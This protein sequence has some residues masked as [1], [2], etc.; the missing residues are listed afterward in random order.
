MKYIG[1]AFAYV[2]KNFIFIFI[3]ALLPSYF[4]SSSMDFKNL[5]VILDNVLSARA[6]IDFRQIFVFLSPA[7]SGRWPF[8]LVCFVCSLVCAPMLLGFIE[9]H[10]RIGSRSLKGLGGRFNYNF[11]TVLI[12][13]LIGVAVYEIWALIAAGLLFAEVLFLGG[14]ARFIVVLITYLALIALLCWIGML[15]LLWIPCRL[16]TGYNLF[17]AL[18]YSNRLIAGG[19][20]RSLL[21]AVLLPV[22]A[23]VVLQFF[24]VWLAVM[25]GFV[26]I[27]FISLELTILVLFLYFFALMF[28]VYFDLTGEERADLEKKY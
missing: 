15:C 26:L 16:V 25:T 6:D 18:A 24:F 17:E 20:G 27:E 10:M 22:L 8:V 2:F 3:F 21:L 1:G 4:L 7:V 23:G 9:K 5:E 11:L 14:V 12:V 28:V 19:K 13:M